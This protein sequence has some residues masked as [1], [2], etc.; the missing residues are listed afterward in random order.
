[1]LAK[2]L[3][4]TCGNRLDVGHQAIGQEV[5]QRD[6]AGVGR[7]ACSARSRRITSYNV[8]YTKLLRLLIRRF[9]EK[10]GQDEA[11]VGVLLGESPED[12]RL[13]PDDESPFRSRLHVVIP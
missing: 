4:L 13:G 1:M 11:F 12:S 7:M 5:I 10:A 6:V 2:P 9:E 3:S 8:C